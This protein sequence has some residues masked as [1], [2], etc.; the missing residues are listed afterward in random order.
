MA[1]SPN[2][3]AVLH[4]FREGQKVVRLNHALFKRWWPMW[5]GA[6]VERRG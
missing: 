5:S 2:Y 1:V 6:G 3:D 4:Q